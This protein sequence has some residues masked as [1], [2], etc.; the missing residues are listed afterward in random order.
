MLASSTTQ[1]FHAKLLRGDGNQS[2]YVTRDEYDSVDLS[3]YD[4]EGLVLMSSSSTDFILDTEDYYTMTHSS[5]GTVTHRLPC[6][7]LRPSISSWVRTY[8]LVTF[9]G[10]AAYGMMPDHSQA[11]Y[12]FANFSLINEYLVAYGGTALSSTH[13]YWSSYFTGAR[14]YYFGYSLTNYKGYD[15]TGS[16]TCRARAVINL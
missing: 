15:T 11:S 8:Q 16:T 7:S 5:S 4:K 9:N 2:H 14:Y 12:I 1:D 10:A 6:T 3:E 13:K